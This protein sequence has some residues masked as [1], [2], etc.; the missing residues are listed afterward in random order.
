MIALGYARISKKGDKKSVSIDIQRDEIVHYCDRQGFDL[1]HIVTHDG[2]SGTK[3]TRFAFLD[4]AVKEFRPSCVVYYMQDRIARDVGLMDYLRTLVKRGIDVHEA[5]AGKVDLKTANGR[6]VVNIRSAV[7][8]AYAE[9]IGEK[10][11]KAMAHLRNN[12][13]RYSNIAPMGY[14]FQYDY[15]DSG[16]QKKFKLIEDP[17]EQRGLVILRE[18]AQAGLGARRALLILKAQQYTG[19]SSVKCIFNALKRIGGEEKT[20]ENLRQAK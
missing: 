1:A 17:E 16:G 6:M 11:A 5:T 3:R 4:S 2:I 10:T 8:A 13:R 19:R 18:C 15:T 7:D 12:A 14:T 20:D 9:V